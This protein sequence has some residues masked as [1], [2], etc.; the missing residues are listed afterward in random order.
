MSAGKKVARGLDECSASGTG[1]FSDDRCTM[2]FVLTA[3]A[4]TSFDGCMTLACAEVESCVDSAL[5]IA[6]S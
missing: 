3:P 2:V 5:G 4:K 6:A 1:T